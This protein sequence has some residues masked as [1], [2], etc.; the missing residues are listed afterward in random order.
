MDIEFI[1]HHEPAAPSYRQIFIVP[2]RDV[3]GHIIGSIAFGRDIT[4]IREA[5]LKLKHFIENLPGM[6]YTFQ[7]SGG[8]ARFPYVSPGI[9]E[10]YGL[11]PRDVMD[12][13][14]PIHMLAPPEDRLRIEA[15]V[16]ESGRTMT[17]FR[18][19]SRVCRPGLPVRWLDVRS[20]PDKQADGSVVWHG[21]MLDITE[22]KQVEAAL[23]ASEERMRLFFESTLVGM[24]ITS[25]QKGWLQV[26]DKICQMLGYSREELTQLTWAQMTFPQDLATDLTLFERMLGGEIDNYALEKRFVRK[27]GGIVFTDLVV[28][29]ARQADRSVDYVLAML[30]DIT[31][32]KRAEQARQAYEHSLECMDSVN[33]AILAATNPEQMMRN[34]LGVVLTFFDCDRAFLLYPCDPTAPEWRVP[35][36]RTRSEYP[37]Q[38]A[39]G[40]GAV[41]MDEDVAGILRT[42]LDAKGVVKF[43]P[44]AERAIPSNLVTQYGVRSLLSMALSPKLD[45]PWQFGIQQCDHSRSWT[46]DEEELFEK[47]GWRLSDALTSLLMY[48]N[49]QARE[50]EFRTLAENLPDSLIRYDSQG[51]RTYVNPALKRMFATTAEQLIG[52]T[53]QETNPT[54]MQMPQSYQCALAHTLA[55]GER[56]EFEIQLPSS[57]GSIRTGLCIIAAERAPDRQIIGAISIGHDITE[58]KR[59]EAELERYRNHL[60]QLVEERTQALS[61]AKEAAETA[62]RAKSHFLAAASHDLRQPLQAIGLFNQALSMTKL[63]E[64]Q[65]RI[66]RN[67]S[68]SVKSLG[69]LLNGLL[70]LSRLDAGIIQPHPEAIQARRLLRMMGAEFDALA[71]EKDLHLDLFCPRQGLVLFSDGSLLLTV[72]RNLISNAVKYTESGGVLV[73]IRKREN[74]ALIQVWDTGI[75]IAPGQIDSIFEEYFQVANPQRDRAKGVGLGLTIVKRLSQLL[76]IGLSVRS[77]EGQGSVF[78]LSVPLNM[79]SDPQVPVRATSMPQKT[80]VGTRLAGLRLVVVEDDATAAE[81]LKLSLEMAGAQ[82]TLF[83]SAE[84]ALACPQTMAVDHYISDYRLPGINGLALLEALQASSGVP[85]KAVVLTGNTSPDQLTLMQSSRWQ[86]LFKPIDLSTLLSAMGL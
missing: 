45:K 49:L 81:A 74:R 48:R 83:R 61:S 6:A 56:S 69:E 51:R 63:D 34:V 32:R 11:Q 85:I 62:T 27:D 71:Q 18:I 3:N 75:G 80:V 47:I 46:R 17:P 7:V 67:I 77:Q 2:E 5:E 82:V 70:D 66:S 37:G 60:E 15:A 8:Q 73:G 12:D 58:R 35:M 52:K 65:R 79:S 25:P 16:A 41:P 72:L 57:D 4:A 76:G 19:E 78:E 13:M 50:Q 24:A 59:N 31:E 64:E 1:E 22:R 28:G 9:E 43:G 84:E 42:L 20:V 21:I 14:M 26:N 36:E 53:L 38:L 10:L 55:T 33:I 86:V 68:K 54:S 40:M 44:G 30:E 39:S 29:C 23:R